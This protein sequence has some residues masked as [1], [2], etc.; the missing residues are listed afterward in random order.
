MRQAVK[1]KLSWQKKKK[2]KEN[3]ARNA[4]T[5]SKEKQLAFSRVSFYLLFLIRRVKERPAAV[6]EAPESGNK[7]TIK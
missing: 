4:V 5:V 6:Q 7:K 1:R 3:A 2:Q